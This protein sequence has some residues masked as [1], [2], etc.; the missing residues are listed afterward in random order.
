MNDRLNTTMGWVLG[1]AAFALG[2]SI[3]ADM[4]FHG[5]SG[6]LPETPGYMIEAPEEGAAV[7][8]GPS[9]AELLAT[10]SAE[11]G[12][13][14][15]AKCST[16]H[17]IEQGG[18]NGIGPNLYAVLGA[19]IGS[20]VPG[21]D[22]SSALSGHGGA[23]DYENMDA[24]LAS[25]RGFADGTKMSFAGL[26]SG[27]DRANIILYMREYGGGP[28]LP[29]VEVAAPADGEAGDAPGAG[30]GAVEGE[31]A[32]AVEAAGAMGADQPVPEN[33]PGT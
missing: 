13:A 15:F 6:E 12:A 27:E 26:G 17:S 21:Y 22:Y 8:A 18:A 9:L 11:A 25:P 5:G 16:C 33:P 30:P 4:Y 24:W 3:V 20:H 7:D 10:G 23:W 2:G 29:A 14:V 1:S 28:E 19:S 31:P 32:S